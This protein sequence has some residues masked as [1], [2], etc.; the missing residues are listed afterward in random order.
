MEFCN[1][2]IL[3]EKLLSLSEILNPNTSDGI[4]VL[5]LNPF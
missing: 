3:L 2:F 5:L 1:K 4:N